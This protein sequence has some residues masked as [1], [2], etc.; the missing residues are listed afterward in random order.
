MTF[1]A[2][3]AQSRFEVFSANS[4]RVEVFASSAEA[5]DAVAVAIL[6]A[7][8]ENPDIVLGL[9]TGNTPRKVYAQ[10]SRAVSSGRASFA[11][12][13]TFN[14]DEYCGL[15]KAHPDSFAAYMRRELFDKTDFS[16]DRINLIDGAAQDSVREARRFADALLRKPID[17]QLLGLGSNG[18]IGFNEPGSTIDSR[19][20][21]VELSA[22][23]LLA[24]QET[25]IELQDVPSHATTMGIADILGA[26]SIIILATGSAKAQ[27]V[28]H[29]IEGGP[30]ATWPGSF[31]STHPHVHWFLDQDAARFLEKPR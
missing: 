3:S 23:T 10:L 22:E 27:A 2:I 9:A 8:A 13:T 7:V 12:A 28:R 21:C 6:R 11:R 16:D 15:H 4:N 31:L 18:H 19:V 26:R 25:L 29:C 20:R 17:L 14:L 30:S 1:G 5:S 24:N